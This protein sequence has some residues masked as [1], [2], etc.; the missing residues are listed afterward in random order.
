[1]GLLEYFDIKCDY[2]HKVA[3]GIFPSDPL[4]VPVLARLSHLCVSLFSYL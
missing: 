3:M 2:Q 4:Q 1:M